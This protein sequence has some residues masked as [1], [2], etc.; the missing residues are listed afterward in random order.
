M[1]FLHQS[2]TGTAEASGGSQLV[3][4]YI[5]HKQ[6]LS[7]AQTHHSVQGKNGLRGGKS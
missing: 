1:A 3:C 7:H 4:G 2:V 6:S 5:T